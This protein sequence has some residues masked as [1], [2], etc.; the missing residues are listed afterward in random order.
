MCSQA[1]SVQTLR[2]T[3]KAKPADVCR[4]LKRPQNGVGYLQINETQY[5]ISEQEY[6]I[7]DSWAGRLWW[8]SQGDGTVYQIAQ[9]RDGDLCCDCASSIYNGDGK[10]CKHIRAIRAAYAWLEEME[11]AEAELVASGCVSPF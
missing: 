9:D 1:G 4:W 5:R 11:K 3:G 2:E 8:L 10:N 6:T 7:C